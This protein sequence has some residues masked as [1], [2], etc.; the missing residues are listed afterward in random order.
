MIHIIASHSS[1]LEYVCRQIFNRWLG[2]EFDIC[3]QKNISGDAN[4][5]IINYSNSTID[6]ALNITPNGL[7]QQSGIGNVDTQW[8]GEHLFPTECEFGFDIFSAVFYLISRYEEYNCNEVDKHGRYKPESSTLFK[9]GLHQTPVVDKWVEELR[10]ALNKQ[11]VC[12]P[13]HTPKN[14]T[15]IDVDNVYAYRN[16]GIIRHLI[17]TGMDLAKGETKSVA[18]RWKTLLHINDDPFF[19]IEEVSQ[20][21][22]DE[23]PNNVIFFHCGCYGKFDKKTV[24]PSLRYWK[25][26]QRIDKQIVV[27]LHISYRAATNDTALSLEKQALEKCLGRPVTRCRFHYLRFALPQGYERLESMGFTDDYSLAYSNVAGYRAGTGRDFA[28]YNIEKEAETKLIV[29]PLIVMDK[30]LR[31]NMNLSVDE[32]YRF[33]D[34]LRHESNATGGDFTTLFHNENIADWNGWGEWGE[35]FFKR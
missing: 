29:H 32:A 6:N 11:T 25:A 24:V 14:L 2:V 31:S 30:T 12:I 16:K 4:E 26:K 33:I 17:S 35:R 8:D 28:F 20:S 19:N 34:K 10:V 27:G 23:N 13:K 3:K 9:Q 21:L 1:R 22:A 5:A 7:M 15:T 18:Q